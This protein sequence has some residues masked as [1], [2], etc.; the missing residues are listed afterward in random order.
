M[1][2]DFAVVYHTRPN[3][4]PALIPPTE[5]LC[6]LVSLVGSIVGLYGVG[7]VRAGVVAGWSPVTVVKGKEGKFTPQV[8][9]MTTRRNEAVTMRVIYSLDTV[10]QYLIVRV[11]MCTS[12]YESYTELYR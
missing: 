10:C 3:R 7:V 9:I 8:Q 4:C 12:T 2:D 6:A 11:C 1:K 5:G